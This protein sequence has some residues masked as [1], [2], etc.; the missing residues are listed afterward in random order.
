V[1]TE[2]REG[3]VPDLERPEAQVRQLA[4]GTCCTST[5]DKGKL[6][7]FAPGVAYSARSRTGAEGLGEYGDPGVGHR[8]AAVEDQLAQVG[9]AVLGQR[10]AQRLQPRLA[11]EVVPEVQRAERAAAAW[12][13]AR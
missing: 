11:E 9:A 3:L 4:A 8:V 10:R 12:Q 7:C 2:A 6:A 1:L 5:A 13:V